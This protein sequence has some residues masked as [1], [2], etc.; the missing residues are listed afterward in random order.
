[1]RLSLFLR[2]LPGQV[3]SRGPTWTTNHAEAHKNAPLGCCNIAHR[4]LSIAIS[5]IALM[6]AHGV[7]RIWLASAFSLLYW[8]SSESLSRRKSSSNTHVLGALLMAKH[9]HTF[10]VSTVI[11]AA[12]F[13]SVRGSHCSSPF[14]PFQLAVPRKKADLRNSRKVRSE[15]EVPRKNWSTRR[16]SLLI[17]ILIIPGNPIHCSCRALASCLHSL[18]NFSILLFCT[19][20]SKFSTLPTRILVFAARR[21]SSLLVPFYRLPRDAS[22]LFSSEPK[23]NCGI[24]DDRP[25]KFNN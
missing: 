22:R 17:I 2:W 12:F 6:V 7:G 19:L 16:A 11:Y 3:I 25:S 13:E 10:M 20:P 21:R 23:S 8:P 15:A 1:M 5:P 4:R 9:A 18:P 24:A 14:R